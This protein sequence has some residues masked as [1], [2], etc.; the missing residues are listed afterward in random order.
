MRLITYIRTAY[1]RWNPDY[2]CGSV[3]APADPNIGNYGFFLGYLW[4]Q[5]RAERRGYQ[6][7]TA[8]W[9]PATEQAAFEPQLPDVELVKGSEDAL[10]IH[11]ILNE[12]TDQF[13][14]QLDAVC[15]AWMDRICDGDPESYNRALVCA[16]HTQ[17]IDMRAFR[18]SDFALA[19]L[20]A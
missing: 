19:A 9:S 18:Q 15:K 1:N 13:R 10:I 2:Q 6:G 8:A 12:I 4:R 16:E 5:W 17:E 11:N 3:N 20:G 7:A 14:I